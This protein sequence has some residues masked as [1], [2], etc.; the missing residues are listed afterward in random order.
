MGGDDNISG[1]G[2][3]DLIYGGGDDD[4][5]DGGGGANTMY[6]EGGD[7]ALRAN[8]VEAN[9]IDG[10]SG[11]DELRGGFGSD[12]LT[13]GEGNDHLD[14]GPGVDVMTGSIGDDLYVIDDV[15]DVAAELAGEGKD[16]IR[17]YLASYTLGAVFENLSG[18]NF[19]DA[20]ESGQRLTGN[21]LGNIITGSVGNDLLDGAVGADTLRGFFGNDSYMIDN[22]GDLIVEGVEQGSDRLFA[23]V[24]YTLNA[25]AEVE[26]MSTTVH[27]GTAA[28]NLTGNELANIIHGN[29]GA[30]SLDGKAGADTLVGR[31][32]DDL[33]H[34]DNAG[35]RIVETAGQ[36][37]DR[38]FAS[39]S[40]TLDAGVS[41]ETLTTNSNF[42]TIAINL[43]GLGN[44]SYY[45]DNAADRVLE[46]A[47]EG[48]DRVFANAS[49]TLA[50]GA[51]V[52][53]LTTNASTGVTAIN[54]TGN[55]LTNTIV[56]N[57]AANTLN[58]GGGADTMFGRLGDDFYHVDNAADRVMENAGEGA[59][60]LFT[61]VSYTLGAGVS[62]ETFT[63]TANAGTGA[64]NLT[65]NELANTIYGNDGANSIDGKA[66]SDI[67]VGRAGGD[68]FAFTTALGATNVDR[69]VDF[70]SGDRVALDDAI[71]AGI[72]TPGA[73]NAAAFVT[74]AAAQD[75]NDRLVYNQATGQLFYDADGNGAGA[76]VLFAALTGAPVLTA[77][78]FMVI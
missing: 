28:I 64:I 33:Y 62:V 45:V 53:T 46:N 15:N 13:G 25:G 55:E 39:V 36:G 38:V 4:F 74:G 21:T 54:L 22:A 2:G 73:F 65:G 78:D 23:A 40:Y 29:D 61:G 76:A 11:D 60:R 31:L 10:G 16:E 35:D 9:L 24:S 19:T 51:S 12:T 49:Y 58:G 47:G 1:G 37:T 72:G 32:G 26:L 56:G 14:G 69:I 59:D 20:P 52:E 63:T 5:V 18:N 66:G 41:V 50:A 67:L 8:G 7:D 27:T 48:A 30:N 57:D 17:T 44:D 42:G 3:G 77:G 75:A 71:F 34:V 68:S 43:T 6:G 70:A